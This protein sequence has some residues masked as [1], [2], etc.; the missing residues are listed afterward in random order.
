M[1]FR[2]FIAMNW[3]CTAWTWRKCHKLR[4]SLTHVVDMVT[5]TTMPVGRNSFNPR[6]CSR[7]T[8]LKIAWVLQSK[9]QY[10]IYTLMHVEIVN[11]IFLLSWQQTWRYNNNHARKD[12][13]EIAV[14]ASGTD[15]VCFKTL[16]RVRHFDKKHGYKTITCSSCWLLG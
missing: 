1:K 11:Q 12:G 5:H 4:P 15:I 14:F 8:T 10:N 16:L 7:E 9:G 3:T 13:W 6:F 2:K